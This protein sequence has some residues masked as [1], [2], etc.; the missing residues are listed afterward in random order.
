MTAKRVFVTVGTTKF[1][2]LIQTTSK[3]EILDILQSLGYTDIQYQVGNG[4]YT[5]KTHKVLH[6]SYAKYFENFDEQ[7]DKSD[8]VISHAG[9]GTCLQVLKKHKPLIVVINDDLMDNHQIELAEQLEKDGLL[10]CCNCS[11]LNE[12]LLKDIKK[13]H[14]YLPPSGKLF[15]NYLDKC[16]GFT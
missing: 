7:I 2:K 8:L 12:T 9:A 11:N 1:D 5:E 6:L 16:M 4:T 3:S 14:K 13:L 10:Y 15:S